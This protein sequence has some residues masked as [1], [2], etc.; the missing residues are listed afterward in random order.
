M[1]FLSA[2]L[3]G[4]F[5]LQPMVAGLLLL[6]G[7]AG[8][9]QDPRRFEAEVQALKQR[10]EATWNPYRP[11]L[12]FTGSSSIRLW[13]GLQA[14]FPQVQIVNTGF[15]G[16]QASDL[17]HYLKDLVLDYNPLKVFIYEGDNDLAEGKSANRALRDLQ[18]VVAGIRSRYP[19]M[20]IV[21]IAAKP[22]LSRWKLRARYQRFNRKLSSWAASDPLLNF[23]DVWGPMLLADGSL[24]E[25]LFIEDGLHMNSAGYQIWQQVLAPFLYT[26]P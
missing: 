5:R 25:A 10:I 18:K 12:L 2:C 20:P 1:K 21:L 16:S 17:Q 15:G 13:E 3:T 9:G 22:S 7:A 26:N 4:K 14:S 6:Y 8:H 11:T 19:G 23:A 24:N